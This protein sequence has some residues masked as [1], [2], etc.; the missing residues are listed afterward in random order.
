MVLWSC[1]TGVF[2]KSVFLKTWWCGGEQKVNHSHACCPAAGPTWEWS[3]DAPF[4]HGSGWGVVF[5]SLLLGTGG[6]VVGF[7]DD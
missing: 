4:P 5:P 2:L 6:E 1:H 7:R 3:V